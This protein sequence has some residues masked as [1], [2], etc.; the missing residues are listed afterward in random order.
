MVLPSS[1]HRTDHSHFAVPQQLHSTLLSD[2]LH[3]DF[4]STT[5]A[6]ATVHSAG[7]RKMPRV[8]PDL[9]EQSQVEDSIPKCLSLPC[10]VPVLVQKGCWP[11]CCC[12][13]HPF[14][15]S[16]SCHPSFQSRCDHIC[17][18]KMILSRYDLEPMPKKMKKKSVKSAIY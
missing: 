15:Y 13:K 18:V 6:L 16:Y 8:D 4:S 17:V 1:W 11:T 14:C 3:M 10:A 12:N 2:S 5:T 9:F 7:M